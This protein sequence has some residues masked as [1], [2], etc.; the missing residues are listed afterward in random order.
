MVRAIGAVVVGLAALVLVAVVGEQGD[1]N[2]ETYATILWIVIAAWVGV[3]VVVVIA[4]VG[5]ARGLR[6]LGR[7][8]RSRLLISVGVAALGGWLGWM[9]GNA[10]QEWMGETLA[11]CLAVGETG[12]LCPGEIL[13]QWTPGAVTVAFV[14]LAWTIAA[15]RR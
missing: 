14:G 4:L 1:L 6:L 12:S 7:E 13:Y 15:S 9:A 2:P 10:I 8:A 11:P 3:L 5:S